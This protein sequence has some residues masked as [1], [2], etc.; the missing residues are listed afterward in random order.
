MSVGLLSTSAKEPLVAVHFPSHFC[1][2]VLHNAVDT[3]RF[4]EKQTSVWS[5]MTA[6]FGWSD[7]VF[8][9]QMLIKRNR[10]RF[11]LLFFF[12]FS[13]N[14]GLSTHFHEEICR[15]ASRRTPGFPMSW[16]SDVGPFLIS[17]FDYET[18]KFPFLVTHHET[19]GHLF[20]F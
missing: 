12:L 13:D 14:A 6:V 1:S 3:I 9:Q 18:L 8:T 4:S 7:N 17:D 16:F 11:V 2:A 10:S 5:R 15:G 19:R 20:F